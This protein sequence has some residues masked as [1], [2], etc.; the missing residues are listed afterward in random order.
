MLPI[1]ID[2]LK[3]QFLSSQRG[4][5]NPLKNAPGLNKAFLKTINWYNKLT[6]ENYKSW[7]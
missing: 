1:I 4:R 2:S 3:E 5:R 6:A 7:A